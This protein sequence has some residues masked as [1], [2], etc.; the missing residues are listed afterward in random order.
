MRLTALRIRRKYDDTLEGEI[1]LAGETGKVAL[2]VN[3][4]LCQRLVEVCADALVDVAKGVARDMTAELITAT[5][6]KAIA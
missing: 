3:D 5:K 1:E 6:A 2:A 4:A